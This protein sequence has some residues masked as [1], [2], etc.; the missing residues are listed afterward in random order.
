MDVVSEFVSGGGELQREVIFVALKSCG[1]SG[2]TAG[3]C[4]W[5]L[6]ILLATAY[7]V[8]SHSSR[9]SAPASLPRWAVAHSPERPC[10]G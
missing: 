7:L 5:I 8:E 2:S 1:D 3:F 4:Y 6:I 10:A 9:E